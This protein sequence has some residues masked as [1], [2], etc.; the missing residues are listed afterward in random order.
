MI[1]G[2]EP[3]IHAMPLKY[4]I[5]SSEALLLILFRSL[6]I[7][8]VMLDQHVVLEGHIALLQTSISRSLNF[9]KCAKTFLPLKILNLHYRVVE[10]HFNGQCRFLPPP[11]LI[12]PL[13]QH[14]AC[15]Q[16]CG[17]FIVLVNVVLAMKLEEVFLIGKFGLWEVLSVK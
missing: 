6:N 3:S 16:I 2:S 11:P 12:P 1:G 7:F 8:A 9:L 14:S 5:F 15:R 13:R 4:L 17:T 10:P